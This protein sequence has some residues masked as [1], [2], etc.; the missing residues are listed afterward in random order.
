MEVFI[1]QLV[2]KQTDGMV[3]LKR[4][5]IVL[6]VVLITLFVVFFG[7][8]L[9]PLQAFGFLIVVGAAY[10]GWYLLNM[11]KLEYE[12]IN[13]N[14]DIDIDK[15]V[16]QSKRVRV[17]SFKGSD[18]EAVGRYDA[19]QQK[20]KKYARVVNASENENDTKNT[21]YA[22]YRDPKYGNTLVL[23]TPNEKFLESF[24]KSLPRPMQANVQLW[25]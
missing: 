8:L 12:Y 5:G 11:T 16:A 15:I 25:N 21:W 7:G 20:N 24:K 18:V 22:T 19:S 10:G 14:G 13:T 4:V 23:F 3:T 17:C 2:K 1:E 6:A 9:G